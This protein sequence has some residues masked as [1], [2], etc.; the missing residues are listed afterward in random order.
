MARYNLDFYNS[1]VRYNTLENQNQTKGKIM[2]GNPAPNNPDD[3]L[4]LAED[5]ADG[6]QTLEAAVGVKQNTEAVL[7][8]TIAAY[9]AADTQLGAAKAARGVADVAVDT[10]DDKAKAFL[11]EARKVLTHY[12]GETWNVAWEATGFP[13]QSTAVPRS[14]EERMNLCASLQAYFT[15][16][17]AQESAQFGV[18]AALAQG[19]FDAA[20]DARDGFDAKDAA[21]TLKD[22]ALTTAFKNL[23]KRVRGLITELETLLADDDPRW[24]EFGLSRPSDPDNPEKVTGLV[25]TPNMPGDVMVKW[26]RAPRATRYRVYKQVL[27]VDAAPVNI[28]TV[29][30]RQ[31]MLE[32]LPSGKVV[33]VYIVAAND[34]GEAPASEA[35]EV[36]IP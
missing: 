19:K 1:G 8:G 25:L 18:T 34:A 7:R 24:H 23:K 2:A 12:L 4:A 28:E 35:G 22:Q 30:D 13:N 33:R 21:V 20:S 15:N 14:P 9:R 6:L 3:L 31:F 17:P 36:L 10:A 26:G 29:H 16:N 27:T 32:G 11:R 5:I